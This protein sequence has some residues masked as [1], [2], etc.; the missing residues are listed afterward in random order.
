M[1]APFFRH[2]FHCLKDVGS[3][4]LPTILFI[5]PH[6]VDIHATPGIDI[7]AAAGDYFPILVHDL[8]ADKFPVFLKTIKGGDELEIMPVNEFLYFRRISASASS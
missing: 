5:H 2:L 1:T 8:F 4:F 3:E 6:I 7:A